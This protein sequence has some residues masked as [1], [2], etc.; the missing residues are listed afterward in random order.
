MKRNWVATF[1]LII[2]AV[3]AY[4]VVQSV[5]E[6][7]QQAQ[8]AFQPIQQANSAMQTQVSELLNPT[9][10]VIPDPVTIIHDVRALARLETIQYSIE[11]VITAEI[12]QGTFDFLFGD[13]L[14]FVAWSGHCGYRYGKD[15]PR[16]YANGKWCAVCYASPR[17]DFYCYIG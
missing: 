6:G 5:R 12:G 4:F 1:L 16:K 14:L 8:Q 10:T 7:A 2:V 13:R 3:A 9:P 11:K 17:R 15:R